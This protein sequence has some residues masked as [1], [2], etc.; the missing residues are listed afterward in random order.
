M[1]DYLQVF[2]C[3]A[4]WEMLPYIGCD[5]GCPGDWLGNVVEEDEG[6]CEEDG[7]LENFLEEYRFQCSVMEAIP[8]V[9]GQEYNL[10][11]RGEGDQAYHIRQQGEEVPEGVAVIR[12][13]E[14][15]PFQFKIVPDQ[16]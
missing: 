16:Q 8:N 1:P 4:C 14:T 15:L 9:P 7:F 11:L 10:V 13:I 12:V 3:K 5:H 2:Y 6:F